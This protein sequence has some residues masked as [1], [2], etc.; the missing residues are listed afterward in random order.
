MPKITYKHHRTNESEADA[1]QMVRDGLRLEQETVIT[2]SR[3]VGD[4]LFGRGVAFAPS[5]NFNY[6]TDKDG[7]QYM[8]FSD[9]S[10]A[11]AS[12][13]NSTS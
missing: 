9:N 2:R 11:V 6:S 4:P 10:S 8:A 5:V 13:C 1:Q 7:E 3:T 12:T